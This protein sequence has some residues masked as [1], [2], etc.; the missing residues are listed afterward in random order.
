MKH[1][2]KI[3]VAMC[4]LLSGTIMGCPSSGPFVAG[5]YKIFFDDNCDATDDSVDALF[6]YADGSLEYVAD[7]EA[8]AGTWSVDGVAFTMTIED[9]LA[10]VDLNGD[11]TVEVNTL[12]DGMYS[13]GLVEGCFSAMRVILVAK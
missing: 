2:K 7:G 10:D 3:A 1:T 6:L 12:V 9:Y 11:A 13:V 4:L 5:P 8:K